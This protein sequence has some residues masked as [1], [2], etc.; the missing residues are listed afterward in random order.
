LFAVAKVGFLKFCLKPVHKAFD[1]K[2][3]RSAVNTWDSNN[4]CTYHRS[5]LTSGSARANL[6]LGTL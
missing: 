2:T 5:L 1:L 4:W 6:S 3:Q